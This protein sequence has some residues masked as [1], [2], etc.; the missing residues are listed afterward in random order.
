MKWDRFGEA[1]PR[2]LVTST[3]VRRSVRATV[4]LCRCVVAPLTVS[5]SRVRARQTAAAGLSSLRDCLRQ[6]V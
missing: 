4:T 1:G 2:Q 6:T 5:Y 3:N